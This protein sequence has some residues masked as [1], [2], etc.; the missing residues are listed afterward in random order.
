MVVSQTFRGRYFGFGFG[1]GL[2]LESQIF[3]GRY[4]VTECDS[5][6]YWAIW[7]EGGAEGLYF[8]LLNVTLS[9]ISLLM[10]LFTPVVVLF[11]YWVN[12]MRL[13]NLRDGFLAQLSAF[14]VAS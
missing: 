1:F 5:F 7:A 2:D 14:L 4:F 13:F 11:Y 3:K 12:H 8:S 10:R 9:V 6:R